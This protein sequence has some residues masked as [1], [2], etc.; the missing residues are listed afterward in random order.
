[1]DW[2]GG[3]DAALVLRSVYQRDGAAWLRAGAGLISQSNPDR[4]MEETREKLR[5]V[6]RFL[7]PRTGGEP[8]R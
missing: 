2:Q 7:V 5:S 3:L 6:S 8:C 1:V 4:E